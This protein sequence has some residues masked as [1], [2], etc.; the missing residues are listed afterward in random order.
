MKTIFILMVALVVV[1]ACAHSGVN[2]GNPLAVLQIVPSDPGIPEDIKFFLG[3]WE[4]T[5]INDM[6]ARYNGTARLFV[7]QIISRNEAVISTA[8]ESLVTNDRI[9]AQIKR[10]ED[11]RPYLEVPSMMLTYTAYPEEHCIKGVRYDPYNSDRATLKRKQIGKQNPLL[12]TSEHPS[13]ATHNEGTVEATPQRVGS[14]AEWP[15]MLST[16]RNGSNGATER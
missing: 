4:G 12:S 11:A 10:Q 16:E 2:G 7:S 3:Y 14:A 5:W 15:A 1:T 6:S 8:R 9:K 13:M